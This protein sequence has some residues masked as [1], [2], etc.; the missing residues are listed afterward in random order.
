MVA[1]PLPREASPRGILSGIGR[2]AR[3]FAIG[4]G[5]VL[6]PPSPGIAD[7]Q[8]RPGPEL[9]PTVLIR[10]H[11]GTDG[12]LSL[13]AFL[14]SQRSSD[15]ARVYCWQSAILAA[16][17]DWILRFPM[18]FDAAGLAS[19]DTGAIFS[20][21]EPAI[22]GRLFRLRQETDEALRIES[23]SAI[24]SS[25]SIRIRNDVAFARRTALLMLARR[26]AL[27]FL[28]DAGDD[29]DLELSTTLHVALRQ[30]CDELEML[31]PPTSSARCAFEM[32]RSRSVASLEGRLTRDS[33]TGKI[34]CAVSGIP[35]ARSELPTQRR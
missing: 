27:G 3:L 14:P 20:N 25:T 5:L 34:T 9:D 8:S 33:D 1:R 19:T 22:G 26:P 15:R 13:V 21:L 18:L 10:V 28:L 31:G 30:P 35:R 2:A 24:G 11:N 32:S 4:L 17:A 12:S 29:V 16:G 7:A 6:G 23:V